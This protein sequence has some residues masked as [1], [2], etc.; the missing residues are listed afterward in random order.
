MKGLEDVRTKYQCKCWCLAHNVPMNMRQWVEIHTQC[1]NQRL[2]SLNNPIITWLK[3][4]YQDG[5]LKQMAVYHWPLAICV[6]SVERISMCLIVCVC[7]CVCV[8]V[9]LQG[10]DADFGKKCISN[11]PGFKQE[12]KGELQSPMKQNRLLSLSLSLCFFFGSLPLFLHIFLP[13]CC[14][15]KT[16]I[17]LFVWQPGVNINYTP[18][19]TSKCWIFFCFILY[20]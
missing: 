20:Y 1:I 13:F 19:E 12:T 7:V 14:L 15:L 3:V 8:C 18:S 16:M 2:T 17:H 9:S 5:R 4:D 11:P 6:N 10:Q